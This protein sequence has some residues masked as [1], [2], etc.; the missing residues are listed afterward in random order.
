M[1]LETIIRAQTI[2]AACLMALYFRPATEHEALEALAG[3]R[4]TILAGATDVYPTL[5]PP[6][7]DTMDIMGL[8][9]AISRDATHWRIPAGVTWSD[10]IRAPLPP[11]FDALKCAAGRIGGAQIQNVGTIIGNLCNASPAADGIPCL[12][13]LDAEVELA[14]LRGTRRVPVGDFVT[15]PRR[16]VRA[17]DELVVALRIPVCDAA[18]AFLKLGGRTHLV[19]SIAMVALTLERRE[20]VVTAARLAVGACGPVAIRLREAEAALVGHVPDPSRLTEAHMA[21]L[22]PIDDIRASAGYRR[23]AALELARRAVAGLA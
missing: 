14:S 15:G 12:M 21:G 19:I 5:A 6:L 9:R 4:W 18:S 3:R 8:P 20:G 16:T 13:A 17:V 23:Q 2:Q 10:L 7:P 22:C 1:P 11:Q